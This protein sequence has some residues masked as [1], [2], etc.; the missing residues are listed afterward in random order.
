MHKKDLFIP[1]YFFLFI[2]FFS[3]VRNFQKIENTKEKLE[4]KKINALTVYPIISS[5]AKLKSVL[6]FYMERNYEANKV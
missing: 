1:K 4:A 6:T 2:R 5:A 3:A